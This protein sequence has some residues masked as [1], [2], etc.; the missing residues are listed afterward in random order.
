MCNSFIIP[1]SKGLTSH[2]SF[3][4]DG[5]CWRGSFQKQQSAKQMIRAILSSADNK[6]INTHAEEHRLEL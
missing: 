3:Q 4:V 1:S 5:C 2:W 6:N